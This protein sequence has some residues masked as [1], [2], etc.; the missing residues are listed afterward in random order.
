MKERRNSSKTTGFS[1]VELS[2]VLVIL[3]LLTGGILT[4]QSLIRAAELRAIITEKDK[5]VAAVHSFKDKYF[6]LPGEM[7]NAT[8]F[9]GDTS[10]SGCGGKTITGEPAHFQICSG[11]FVNGMV[12]YLPGQMMSS[13]EAV[14]FWRH[15]AL[16]GLI[17]GAYSGETL[18]NSLFGNASGYHVLPQY[19]GA[20]GPVVPASRA[21]NMNW[22]TGYNPNYIQ[23]TGNNFFT[24]NY[25]NYLLHG[26]SFD[27]SGTPSYQGAMKP[28]EVWSIDKKLDDGQPGMGKVIAYPLACTTVA[29]QSLASS[30]EYLLTSTTAQCGVIFAKVY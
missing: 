28:E 30:A 15:L 14:Q 9:W 16:A 22:Y 27:G 8:D 7:P 11:Y 6:T 19:Y 26:K 2:I 4:G 17:E 5:Y 24:Y 21:M 29:N 20:I 12:D 25:G 10:G 18:T 13:Y 1:L 3:G 23:R